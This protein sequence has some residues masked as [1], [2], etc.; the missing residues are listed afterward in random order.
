MYFNKCPLGL[1]R[2]FLWIL[3]G[4]IIPAKKSGQ[5]PDSK[6]RYVRSRC[7]SKIKKRTDNPQL[8]K[9]IA[10]GFSA[11]ESCVNPRTAERFRETPPARRLRQ[12]RHKRRRPTLLFSSSSSFFS[13]RLHRNRHRCFQLVRRP[14]T[15]LVCAPRAAGLLSSQGCEKNSSPLNTRGCHW[16]P[17]GGDRVNTNTSTLTITFKAKR[18]SLSTLE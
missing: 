10:I 16:C 3:S 5:P 15:A 8:R 7:T 9:L 1:V 17:H 18:C 14:L 4:R 6:S 12:H 11:P 2:D 13:S